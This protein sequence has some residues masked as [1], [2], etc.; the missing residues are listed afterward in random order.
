MQKIKRHSSSVSLDV[1]GPGVD[2]VKNQNQSFDQKG[3][4][5]RS[6]LRPGKSI[7][8][9]KMDIEGET[10]SSKQGQTNRIEGDAKNFIGGPSSW[11]VL[12]LSKVC[13]LASEKLLLVNK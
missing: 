13:D 7:A 3:V 6:K 2:V 4:S 9:Q 12:S 11:Y 1:S 5:E 8:D 10:K